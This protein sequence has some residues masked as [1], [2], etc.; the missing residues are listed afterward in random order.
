MLFLLL[1][2]VPF[3]KWYKVLLVREIDRRECESE[4]F[5]I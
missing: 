3:E 2:S 1:F 5:E 4:N